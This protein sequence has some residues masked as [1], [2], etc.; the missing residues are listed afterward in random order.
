MCGSRGRA[1]NPDPPAP[2]RRLHEKADMTAAFESSF[3]A[4]L[5]TP[6]PPIPHGIGAEDTVAFARRFAVH[7]NNVVAGLCKILQRRFPAVERI[8]GEEFFAAMA[9][10]FVTKWPP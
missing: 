8:V 6:E 4:A 9:R 7:R 3:A 10:V 2:V 5:L 1:G